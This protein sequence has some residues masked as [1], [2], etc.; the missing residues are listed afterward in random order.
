MVKPSDFFPQDTMAKA[1]PKAQ[2]ILFIGIFLL[3]AKG[4]DMGV[5][6]K[7]LASEGQ[8]LYQSYVWEI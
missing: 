8:G 7:T 4:K 1:M 2:K 6:K 3:R 5:I